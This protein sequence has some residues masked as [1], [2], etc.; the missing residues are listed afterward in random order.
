MAVTQSRDSCSAASRRWD[1][2][3]SPDEVRVWRHEAATA[4]R[5]WGFGPEVANL[6]ALGVSE[7]LTNVVRHAGDP[8]CS[9]E[10]K[11]VGSSVLIRVTDRSSRL[12]VVTEPDTDSTS[13]RGLWLLQEM[14]SCVHW[15]LTPGDAG[16]GKT[17]RFVVKAP[18]E[19]KQ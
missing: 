17:V 5:L 13:G 2:V 19:A 14:A 7:L 11:K 4:V 10:L 18:A 9:L 1:I 6:V 8:R 15:F 16:P 3:L 12:P